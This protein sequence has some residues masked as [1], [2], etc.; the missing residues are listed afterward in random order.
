[1]EKVP[2]E[3]KSGQTEQILATWMFTANQTSSVSNGQ[4]E[5]K[6]QRK[7]EINKIKEKP[8]LQENKIMERVKPILSSTVFSWSVVIFT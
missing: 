1:M 8:T 3:Y 4:Y 2:S 5:S 6:D 7:R